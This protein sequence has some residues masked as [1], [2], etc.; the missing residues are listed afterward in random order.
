MQRW[1]WITIKSELLVNVI[2]TCTNRIHNIGSTKQT[3]NSWTTFRL[4]Q[5]S[6]LCKPL[7]REVRELFPSSAFYR[8][9]NFIA[10]SA[11]SN[12]AR[13]TWQRTLVFNDLRVLGHG[14]LT[15]YTR[16]LHKNCLEQPLSEIIVAHPVRVNNANVSP[17]SYYFW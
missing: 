8:L 6:G 16:I 7:N 14:S 9:I 11:N 1:K 5:L 4:I 13:K 15:F 2:E 12:F 17:V 3:Q 10:V